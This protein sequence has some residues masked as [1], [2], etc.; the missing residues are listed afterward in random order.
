MNL[1]KIIQDAL[2]STFATLF[3]VI[4]Y[5]MF[6]RLVYMLNIINLILNLIKPCLQTHA[7]DYIP[8]LSSFIYKH[9]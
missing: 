1:N 6:A 4:W 8:G 3:A 9:D 2:I 7:H 5:C